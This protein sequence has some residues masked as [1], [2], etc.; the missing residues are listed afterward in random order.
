MRELS[1]ERRRLK[2]MSLREENE[3][4]ENLIVG[5]PVS[6]CSDGGDGNGRGL[7]LPGRRDGDKDKHV[8][9]S[10]MKRGIEEQIESR[11]G[12]RDVDGPSGVNETTNENNTVAKRE[13]RR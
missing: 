3:Q 10:E 9:Q 6:C 7:V 13:I 5:S 11:R 12:E 1:R 2:R 8:G 4:G